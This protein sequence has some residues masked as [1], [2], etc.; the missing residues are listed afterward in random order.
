M[1]LNRQLLRAA[2][3]FLVYLLLVPALL[4]I[5]AGSLNWPMGWVYTGL[6]LVSVV[7]SRLIILRRNPDLLRER[8]SFSEAEGTKSWDRI[9]SPF[10][11]LFGPML[12]MI[13][14]GLDKRF[15]WSSGLPVA[16]QVLALLVVTLSFGVAVW[17]MVVNPFFS[18]VARIQ[19]ERGQQVVASGPY[20]WVRHPAYAGS[21]LASLALP[22]MLDALWALVPSLIMVAALVIR[23]RLEDRM[24]VEELEGYRDYARATPY[25]LVPGV[26]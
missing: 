15:V 23:T 7:G 2:I 19:S 4:F 26:W 13:V 5:S 8:A 14:A 6:A 20:R 18:A 12:G 1:D 22:F 17:A 11:G 3:G 24:L 25:R 9:L 10:V 16:I 21:V